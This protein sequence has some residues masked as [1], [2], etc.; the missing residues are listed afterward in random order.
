M[1]KEKLVIFFRRISEATPACLMVM[2]QGNL[3][4]ITWA[5][6]EI[7]LRTGVITGA[8]MVFLSFI[9]PRKWLHNRYTTG[10]LTGAAT[11]GS[12]FLAHPAAISVEAILTGVVAAVLCIA[13]SFIVKDSKSS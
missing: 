13:Y 7:A 11:A 6:W 4:G 8:V 12:D 5:H 10:A 9:E 3:K 2:V 1:L